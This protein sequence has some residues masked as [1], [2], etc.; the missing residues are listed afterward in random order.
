MHIYFSVSFL[1]DYVD[2]GIQHGG[3]DLGVCYCMHSLKTFDPTLLI[4]PDSAD[5]KQHVSVT[6][7][8]A[9][10]TFIYRFPTFP[11]ARHRTRNARVNTT[12]RTTGEREEESIT[13]ITELGCTYICTLE[14][15]SRFNKNDVST[16]GESTWKVTNISHFANKESIGVSK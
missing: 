5:Q 2:W 9:P 3:V 15:Y 7:S 12:V 10:P 6:S 1:F 13:R 11:F 8:A 14:S 16:K 4:R